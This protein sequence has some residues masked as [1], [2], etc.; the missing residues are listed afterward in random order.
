MKKHNTSKDFHH[1]IYE[2]ILNLSSS[3][4]TIY[5]IAELTIGVIIESGSNSKLSKKG[6]N[7]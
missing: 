4:H 2:N 3:N 6:K 7:T 5:R 1:T